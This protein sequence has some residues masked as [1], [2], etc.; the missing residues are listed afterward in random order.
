MLKRLSDNNEK[1][2]AIPIFDRDIEIA[3]AAARVIASS[4]NTILVEGNCL[5]LDGAPWLDLGKHFS[6]TIALKSS[7]ETINRRLIERWQHCNYTA[8]EIEENS[9]LTTFRM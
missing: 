6:T 7:Y 9:I 5:L 3:Q 2:I 8:T 1:Q 4:A